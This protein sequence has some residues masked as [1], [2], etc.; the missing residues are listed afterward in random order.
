MW[1][2]LIIRVVCERVWRLKLKVRNKWISREARGKLSRKVA[3]CRAHDW[4]ANSHDSLEFLWV[5]RR[6]GLLTKYSRNILFCYFIIFALLS[7]YL[8]YIYPHYS[9][10]VRSAFQRENPRIHTWE[11]EI[12][13]FTTNHTD[14]IPSVFHKQTKKKKKPQ[15]KINKKDKKVNIQIT[16]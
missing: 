8:H 3:T 16:W 11:L 2:F 12:T 14:K 10:I 15:N 7:L 13:K 5:S 6:S 9:H 1:S 4:N